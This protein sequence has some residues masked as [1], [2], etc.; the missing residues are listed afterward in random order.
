M[1]TMPMGRQQVQDHQVRE[2]LDKKGK[3]EVH[4]HMALTFVWGGNPIAIDPV[5]RNQQE[6]EI[7]QFAV[8][9][10]YGELR[11][12]DVNRVMNE[13]GQLMTKYLRETG[14]LKQGE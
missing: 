1:N 2:I 8:V 10:K 12:K 5:D 9:S 13:F 3:P 4:M 11:I 7:K 14:A 6:K